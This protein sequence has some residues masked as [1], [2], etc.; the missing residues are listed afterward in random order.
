MRSSSNGKPGTWTMEFCW[1]PLSSSP[2]H[3]H[4]SRQC[5]L[6]V[7]CASTSKSAASGDQLPQ[8]QS[9]QHLVAYYATSQWCH[10]AQVQASLVLGVPVTHP[11]GTEF[12]E[13][14]WEKRVKKALNT[15]EVLGHLPQSH[16]QYTLLRFCLSA[17]KVNDLLRA[18]PV[19]MG[20]Q[21]CQRLSLG[22]R[23][24]LNNI[25]GASLTDLQWAQCTLPVRLGG[26]GIRDPLVERP[27]ARLSGIL[28]FLQKTGAL[29][30]I[31]F[32]G[33]PAKSF[34]SGAPQHEK[35]GERSPI[36][37]QMHR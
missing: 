28:D 31:H 20:E 15:I 26:L 21:S 6:N 22:L 18:C 12:G 37:R 36:P 19:Q 35:A 2:Q 27:A 23:Q 30:D 1:A 3:S 10:G 32:R 34:S 25:L 7:E 9:S 13:Q 17:C 24:C 11:G 4:A 5:V 8:R 29:L 16:I 33:Y 14:A